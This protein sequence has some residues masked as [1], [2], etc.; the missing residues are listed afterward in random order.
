MK[1]YLCLYVDDMVFVHNN[2]KLMNYVYGQL[3]A[4]YNFSSRGP[5]EFY[6]GLAVNHEKD[7]SITLSQTAYID[8]VLE[9]FGIEDTNC[10]HID[11]P[12]VSGP[13]G[14]LSQKDCPSTQEELDR[15]RKRPYAEGVGALQWMVGTTR[16]DIGYAVSAVSRYMSNHGDKHWSAVIRILKYLKNTRTQVLRFRRNPN[17]SGHLVLMCYCDADWASEED[18]RRSQGGYIC[19][20]N[21]SAV[22]IRSM[23]QK[24]VT[25]SSMES[26]Y[27]S[28][29]EAAKE[30]VWFRPLLKEM[31]YPQPGPTVI[32]EDNRAA[33]CLSEG[34]TS[35]NR[36]KHIDVRHHW[37]RQLVNDEIIKLHAIKTQDQQADILTKNTDRS[38]FIKL[39]D[40]IINS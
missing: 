22:A 12:M 34:P 13:A 23:R 37:L 2:G 18:G 8:R 3:T 6:L 9:R 26:E 25:L 35:H 31:G 30:I 36:T 5:L 33:I 28:A 1:V 17:A 19:S 20:I 7:G 11:T 16:P 10:T 21:G 29:G 15:S 40:R 32:W 14:R 39:R 27:V 4:K 38:L 24:I